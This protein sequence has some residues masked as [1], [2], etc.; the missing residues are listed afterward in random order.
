[1]NYL[2][3]SSKELIHYLDFNSQDPIVRRL[4]K[5]LQEESLVEDLVAAGMDPETREFKHDWSY[6]SPSEFIE[7]LQNDVEYMDQDLIEKEREIADL[8]RE[9]TRLSTK[10]LVQFIADVHEKLESAKM[11]E[12]RARRIAEHEKKLREE[13]EHKFEFW[14]KMNNGIR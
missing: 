9:V 2:T 13:A 8:E 1:M 7:K 10:S 5:L 11:E 6:Y 14:D 12:G 3:M 4:V